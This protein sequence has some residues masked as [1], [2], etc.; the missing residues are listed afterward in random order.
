MLLL[1]SAAGEDFEA[2]MLS[3]WVKPSTNEPLPAFQS[4]LYSPC[5][6]AVTTQTEK[7]NITWT[8]KMWG[9]TKL[10]YVNSMLTG[11]ISVVPLVIILIQGLSIL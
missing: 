8:P 6:K 3:K 5:L 10:V 9:K 11:L 7:M 1:D 2:A 4:M